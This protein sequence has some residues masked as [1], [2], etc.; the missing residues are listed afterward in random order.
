MYLVACSLEV[1]D[2][3]YNLEIQNGNLVPTMDQPNTPEQAWSLWTPLANDWG[4]QLNLIVRM[5]LC[6]FGIAQLI[7]MTMCID[8]LSVPFVRM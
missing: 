3:E 1:S 5:A 6:L 8:V 2:Y 4:T 7:L